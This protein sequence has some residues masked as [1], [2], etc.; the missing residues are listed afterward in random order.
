MVGRMSGAETS[1]DLA[2]VYSF[3]DNK[4]RRAHIYLDHEAALEATALPE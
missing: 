4:I 1:V 2:G 3:E